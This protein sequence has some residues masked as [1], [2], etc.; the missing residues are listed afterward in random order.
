MRLLRP[1]SAQRRAMLE[2]ARRRVAPTLYRR[3]LRGI[4]APAWPLHA[5][6][7]K[8]PTPGG[9]FGAERGI[10]DGRQKWHAGIDLYA[11]EGAPVVAMEPGTVI[12]TWNGWAGGDTA[13][14]LVASDADGKVINY[15]AVG[16]DSWNEFHIRAGSHVERGQFLARVGR[17]PKGSTMLHLEVYAPGTTDNH[18]WFEGARPPELLDPSELISAAASDTPAPSPSPSPSPSPWPSPEPRPS[19]SPSPRPSPR[20]YPTPSDRPQAGG[21]GLWGLAALVVLAALVAGKT[22]ALKT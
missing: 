13:R 15:A 1:D 10:H 20:P 7:P 16:R 12:R 18:K 14:I 19:P 9:S 5:R 8:M 21:G 17:Y 6:R 4:D 11:P 22:G 3:P 2:L